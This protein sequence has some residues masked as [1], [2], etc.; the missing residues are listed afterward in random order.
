MQRLI[1]GFAILLAATN[2]H[3]QP[4]QQRANCSGGVVALTYDDGPEPQT[5]LL[6]DQLKLYNLKATF[7]LVGQNV[8]IYPQIAQRIVREGHQVANH[9]WSHADLTTL[10][11]LE[12]AQELKSTQAI[13][14]R[15]TG[16][17]PKF[18]RPP[19]GATDSRVERLI[20]AQGLANTIWSQD[21]YDW[22]G[23]TRWDILNQLTVVPDRGV[24]LMHSR[25]PETTAAVPAM[26]WYF[27]TYWSQTPICAGR[28]EL[29]TTV[30]PTLDWYGMFSY[31]HARLW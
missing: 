9:S 21:S 13:I 10:T 20:V 22:L 7:F 1:C 4:K 15:V 24:F 17:T 18:A 27:N 12:V 5:E 26:S 6:L 11:D 16:V 14:K 8:E 2:A 31:V 30:M 3:A 28:L 19:Y 23:A 29:G 25:M